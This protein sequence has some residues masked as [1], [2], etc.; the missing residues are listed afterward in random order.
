MAGD[1]AIR[2]IRVREQNGDTI[3]YSLS[4]HTYPLALRGDEKDLFSI[5]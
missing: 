5:P 4:G 2:L 1:S 3:R